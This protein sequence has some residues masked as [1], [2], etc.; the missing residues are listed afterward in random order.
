MLV[1]EL[2]TALKKYPT[3]YE[4]ETFIVETDES[5]EVIKVEAEIEGADVVY[6]VCATDPDED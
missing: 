1:G 2:I 6:L 5:I 4:V 3:S